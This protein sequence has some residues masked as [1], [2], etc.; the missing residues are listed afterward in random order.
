MSRLTDNELN[1]SK[2]YFKNSGTSQSPVVVDRCLFLS[3]GAKQLYSNLCQY[4]YGNKKSCFPSQTL[5]MME[6]G[7]ASATL[8]K[9]LDELREGQLIITTRYYNGTL[10]YTIE[11]VWRPICLHHSEWIWKIIEL[12]RSDPDPSSRISNKQIKKTV[13]EYKRSALCKEISC[14]LDGDNANDNV[15]RLSEWFGKRFGVRIISTFD[16]WKVSLSIEE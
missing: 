14:K 12:I 16:S 1:N 3:V 6:L 7:I 2:H 11:D 15:K 10:L 13:D 4:A 8:N 9:Y 5:L